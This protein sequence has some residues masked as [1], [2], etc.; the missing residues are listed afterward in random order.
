MSSG[1]G[2]HG[3]SK[4]GLTDPPSFGFRRSAHPGGRVA[5]SGKNG[6]CRSG[7]ISVR[8]AVGW[9]GRGARAGTK[10]EASDLNS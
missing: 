9:G 7:S 4:F 1:V 3:P 5:L 8:A 2:H 10:K 6:S